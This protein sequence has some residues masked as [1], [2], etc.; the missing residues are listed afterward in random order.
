VP[1]PL[2]DKRRWRTTVRWVGDGAGLA[3]PHGQLASREGKPQVQTRD[4]CVGGIIVS[5]DQ[6]LQHKS[7]SIVATQRCQPNG[8]ALSWSLLNH[9]FPTWEFGMNS[10][11]KTEIGDHSIAA[12]IVLATELSQHQSTPRLIRHL[13]LGINNC[14][15]FHNFFLSFSTTLQGFSRQAITRT[16]AFRP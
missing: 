2:R 15:A 3:T 6:E 10:K 14:I 11:C 4:G 9:N 8:R 16:C 7:A 5:V 13:S 12:D 1:T